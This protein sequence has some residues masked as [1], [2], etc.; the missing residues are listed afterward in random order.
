[1][2]L[3]RDTLLHKRYRILEILGEGG[4]GAVYKAYDENLGVTVALKENLFTSDEYSRQFRVEATILASLRHPN[5]TR[6][7]DHFEEGEGQYLV[8]DYIE[9]EDLRDRMDRLGIIEEEEVIKIGLAICDALTYLHTRIPT[10]LHRDVKPGNVKIA[11]T[12]QVYLVDFGLAKIVRGNQM[13]VTGARAMTPGYSPPE[14][15]GTA[16]TD[17]R[18]DIYSLGATLYSALTGALPE[19]GLARAMNQTELTPIKKHNPKVS[20]KLAATIEKSLGV[21]SEDRFQTAEEMHRSL[22]NARSLTRRRLSPENLVVAPPPS[23]SPDAASQLD[24]ATPNSLTLPPPAVSPVR[25]GRLA[26]PSSPLPVSEPFM[27]DI[28]ISAPRSKPRKRRMG[29]WIWVMVILLILGGGGLASFIFYPALTRQALAFFVAPYQTATATSV[30]TLMP[31]ATETPRPSATLSPTVTP[32]PTVTP[33]ETVTP[34]LIPVTIRPVTPTATPRPSQTPIPKP[35]EI[36]GGDMIAFASDR[37]GIPQIWLMNVDGSNL[38]QLTNLEDGA[39]QPDWSPD[40]SQ[41]IFISPCP[42]E[43]EDYPGAGLFIINID[44]AELT[45]VISSRNGDYDPDWSPDGTRIVFTSLR[46]ALPQ[47]FMFNLDD[48]SVTLLAGEGL[49]NMMP[50]WLAD[51]SKIV[52]I[53]NRRGSFR[54]WLMDPDGLNQVAF[55]RSGNL[56]NTSP[57]WSPD[58]QYLA[59]T[60]RE[61]P[62]G[63]PEIILAPLADDGFSEFHVTSGL[64]P[65]RSPEFSPDGQWMIIEAWP[66]GIDHDIYLLNLDTQEATRITLDPAFDFDPAWRPAPR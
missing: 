35:T 34:T 36:G 41:L 25:A 38:I 51:G 64:S 43:Q 42:G 60:Q 1:M 20:R 14:Q 13:T 53:S 26:L 47:I 4:M 9:G 56:K 6:V 21:Q 58:G 59:F 7:T 29:C 5:L 24:I 23:A 61:L 48:D 18:S 8:M 66:D 44:G 28:F 30:P 62:N 52:F 65:A 50:A 10:I 63:L 17:P 32:Q 3:E 46:N 15:Y 11:P 19:D 39:C 57:I 27:E 37:S 33:T 16:R 54:V 12:G 49:R 2:T 55:S 22:S 45:P 40:G 31:T